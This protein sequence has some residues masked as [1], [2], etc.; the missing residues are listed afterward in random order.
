MGIGLTKLTCSFTLC[1]IDITALMSMICT[2][3][4]TLQFTTVLFSTHCYCNITCSIGVSKYYDMLFH[5]IAYGQ[6][7]I[8][9][10]SNDCLTCVLSFESNKEA[11]S[12]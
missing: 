10:G 2:E 1:S 12:V 3:N 5:G 4:L 8:R 11:S 6:V 7:C 9:V